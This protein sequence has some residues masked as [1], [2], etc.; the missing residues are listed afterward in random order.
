M[1]NLIQTMLELRKVTDILKVVYLRNK[2]QHRLTKWWKWLSILK[3]SLQA[4]GN[5]FQRNDYRG[6]S[7]RLSHLRESLIPRC[8][9]Y[10]RLKSTTSWHS[11]ISLFYRSFTQIAADLQFSALGLVLV[12]NTAKVYNII[13]QMTSNVP[14]V[15]PPAEK[16]VGAGFPHD[17]IEDLGRPFYRLSKGSRDYAD[18]HVQTEDILC[19][20]GIGAPLFVNK[21]AIGIYQRPSL[22]KQR[23]RKT[24]NLIDDLFDA[25]T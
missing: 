17:Q 20:L 12:A 25:L 1:D 8:Y 22:V 9:T 16:D 7:T 11:L 6:I 23:R 21:E 15:S 2:N 14:P 19:Q 4:V 13:S 24:T 10:G 5:D 18:L 3:R